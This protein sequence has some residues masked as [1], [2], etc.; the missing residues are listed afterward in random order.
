MP[1][2]LLGTPDTHH[3]NAA[4]GWLGLGNAIEAEEE[5]KKIAPKLRKHPDVLSVRWQIHA[6]AERWPDALK[7]GEMIADLVPENCLGWNYISISLYRLG[8]LQKAHA[9]LSDKLKYFAGDWITHYNLACYCCQLGELDKSKELLDHAVSLG[10][11][12]EVK[13]QAFSDPDFEPLWKV[14]GKIL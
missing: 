12:K 14:T 9:L 3:L 4:M 2:T 6:K 1:N 11:P 7:V 13:A 8:E 5:L 10:D